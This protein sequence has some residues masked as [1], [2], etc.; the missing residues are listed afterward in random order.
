MTSPSTR[1]GRV[2]C[3]Q[4]QSSRGSP[5]ASHSRTV[6]CLEHPRRFG[7]PS[8]PTA[9]P[10]QQSLASSRGVGRG[11]GG[12]VGDGLPIMHEPSSPS[13][14]KYGVGHSRSPERGST[15]MMLSTQRFCTFEV[16]RQHS[17]RLVGT[18][19]GRVGGRV[20]SWVV[21][22]AVV[23]AV[24]G[25]AGGGVGKPPP[26]PPS[27]VLSQ[28]SPVRGGKESQRSCLLSRNRAMN[29]AFSCS[30]SCVARSVT[31]ACGQPMA[32]SLASSPAIPG[33]S[34][35]SARYTLSST[36]VALRGAFGMIIG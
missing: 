29:L 30:S 21:G 33:V 25:G 14:R 10:M 12:G 23:T 7:P 18:V 13:G 15:C 32:A 3:D 28:T 24:G 35:R 9:P 4:R 19:G 11:V 5:E 31:A 26:P 2:V 34:P 20:V 36:L 27:S 17:H 6:V 1:H 22:R 16:R 8:S